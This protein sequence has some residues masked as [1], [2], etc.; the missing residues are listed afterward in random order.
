MKVEELSRI[1]GGKYQ[2]DGQREVRGV[3]ALGNAGPDDLA[4]VEGD[5]ALGLAGACPAGCILI[6]EGASLPGHTTIEVK[7][8]KL[9][10]IRAVETLL[11]HAETVAGIHPTAIIAPDAQLAKGVSVGPYVVIERG[12][13]VGEGSHLGAGVCLGEGVQ[14]G[15]QCVLY[16]RVVAYPGAHIGDRVILHAGVVVGSD[17]FGYVLA[18]GHYQKFPQLGQVIIEDDVEI[19]SN[20]TI[21][22]GSLG[23]TVIGQGTKLDNLVHVAHNVRIGKN[24]VIAAQ[25]GISGSV[26]IGEQVVIGGQV[27]VADRVRIEDG[28]IIGAQAGIP[29]GKIVRRGLFMW[30]T[31]ARPLAEFKRIYAHLANLPEL[32]QKVKELSR[33][34]SGE[35][36]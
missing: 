2:G 13:K 19:G 35:S 18:E 33:R 10:F 23:T 11:P 6:A 28:A 1:L 34:I 36:R 7:H 21:D 14:V 29:S 17:G 4:F 5:R 20:S 9:A 27:G 26:E 32:A 3:A 25:T 24:C 31:P 12:V 16:P 30:G 15:A 8:P 22:R